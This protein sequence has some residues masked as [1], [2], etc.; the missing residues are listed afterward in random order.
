MIKTLIRYNSLIPS[1]YTVGLTIELIL[2]EA[3]KLIAYAVVMMNNTTITF[4][5]EFFFINEYLI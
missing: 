5:I 2:K 1:I 3:F 4:V